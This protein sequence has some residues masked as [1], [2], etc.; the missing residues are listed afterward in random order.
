MM[1]ITIDIP[2]RDNTWKKLIQVHSGTDVYELNEVQEIK[3]AVQEYLLY[4]GLDRANHVRN[5]NII[6]IGNS[7]FINIDKKNLIRTALLNS[8]DK[9][10]LVHNHPSNSLKA[11]RED[12]QFSN[13]INKLFETFDIEFLDHIIVAEDGFISMMKEE[14]I[15]MEYSNYN[16]DF[17]NRIL[18]YDE[19][20][21]LKAENEVLL[22]RIKNMENKN[23]KSKLEVEN[24]NLENEM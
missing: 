2:K 7:A 6:A 23:I 9:V 14:N 4:I 17:L 24:E 12:I 5:I 22:E 13:I 11:S 19:N 8:D 15:D 3:N 21:K 1:G 16:I 18:V 10:I 20:N